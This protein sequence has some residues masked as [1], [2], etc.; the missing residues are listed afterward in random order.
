MSGYEVIDTGGAPI[1]AWTRGDPIEEAA[2]KQLAFPSSSPGA[3]RSEI[4]CMTHP[5]HAARRSG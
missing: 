4:S 3:T 5:P 1:K 2:R